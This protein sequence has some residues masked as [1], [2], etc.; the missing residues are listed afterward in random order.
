VNGTGDKWKEV[1]NRDSIASQ[2]VRSF[3]GNVKVIVKPDGRMSRVISRR[4]SYVGG[5]QSDH[6]RADE[7][8]RSSRTRRRLSKPRPESVAA[9][10]TSIATSRRSRS[11]D[12][13]HSAVE[14]VSRG[15]SRRGSVRGDKRRS[16]DVA[17]I[18]DRSAGN[19]SDGKDKND[20]PLSK[21]YWDPQRGWLERK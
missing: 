4:S 18:R 17:T 19:E 10:S 7:D 2:S 6:E 12:G 9:G 16:G 8:K 5:N 11:E 20:D 21:Y 14:D 13:F 15:T 3:S 1:S